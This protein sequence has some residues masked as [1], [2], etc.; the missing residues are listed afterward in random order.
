MSAGEGRRC[1][2]RRGH[3]E[4]SY[5]DKAETVGTSGNQRRQEHTVR[6]RILVGLIGLRHTT[7]R[8]TGDEAGMTTAELLGNAALGDFALIVIWTGLR[9]LGLD[10]VEWIRSD[11]LG[12]R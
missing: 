2:G 12:A 10:V 1:S 3:E 5:R 8:A 6:E 4:R 11:L 7:R 9:E